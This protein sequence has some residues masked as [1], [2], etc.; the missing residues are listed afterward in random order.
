MLT[1]TKS[2]CDFFA[3][4]FQKEDVAQAWLL[5]HIYDIVHMILNACTH[6]G[7]KNFF[8]GG[9]LANREFV[10]KHMTRELAHRDVQMYGMAHGKVRHRNSAC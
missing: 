5:S 9:S 2:N 3:E 7:V 6:Y 1:L 10:R 8:V 4:K